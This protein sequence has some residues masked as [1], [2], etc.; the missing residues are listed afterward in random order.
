MSNE[1]AKKIF[2]IIFVIVSF[3]GCRTF[4]DINDESTER[5]RELEQLNRDGETRNAKLEELY[6]SERKGNEA[7]R[8]TINDYLESERQRVEA[9]KR[10]ID[11]ISGILQEG[12]DII[13][14]LFEGLEE[15][16]RYVLSLEEVE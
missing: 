9:E 6:D 16:E 13:K 3:I 10:F 12:G 7:L 15:I 8:G 4:S 11:S 1:M 2:V 5:V 14:R